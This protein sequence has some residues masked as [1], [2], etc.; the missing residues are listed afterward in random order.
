[1]NT[2]S[3]HWLARPEFFDAI[4]R[5]LQEEGRHVDRYVDVVNEHSPYKRESAS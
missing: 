2:W 5:F 4:G 3:A 1:M